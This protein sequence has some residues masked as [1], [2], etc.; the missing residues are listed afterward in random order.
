[1]PL[2]PKR[3]PEC[4]YRASWDYVWVA[5]GRLTNLEYGAI[6]LALGSTSFYTSPRVAAVEARDLLSEWQSLESKCV[7]KMRMV[8]E[9]LA[10]ID[11]VR[12]VQVHTLFIIRQKQWERN[13]ACNLQGV[14]KVAHATLN[15]NYSWH[16]L[17]SE[18]GQVGIM[19]L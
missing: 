7:L 16:Q 6:K 2:M 19:I 5:D 14:P 8:W 12:R 17:V 3:I 18:I 1:M 4:S 9:L 15:A 11:F 13:S 10:R